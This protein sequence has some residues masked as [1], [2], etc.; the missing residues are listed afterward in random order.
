MTTARKSRANRENARSST[1]PKTARGK[2]RAARNAF[3]HGLSIPISSDCA[4]VAEAQT[5][6]Q[7]IAGANASPARLELAQR[8]A[9]AQLDLVRVR[10]VLLNSMAPGFSELLEPDYVNR[11]SEK[12]AVMDRYENR[13]LSRRKSAIRAFNDTEHKSSN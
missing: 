4:L 11:L 7:N 8:I 10:R 5:L 1:G 2:A 12:F 3:S 9:E 6:A 13:A